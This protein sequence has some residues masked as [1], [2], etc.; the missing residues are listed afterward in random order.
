MEN[1]PGVLV[2][3]NVCAATFPRVASVLGLIWC[4]AR[5]MYQ[6]GYQTKGPSGRSKGSHIAVAAAI[7][8]VYP[9]SV[10]S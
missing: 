4:V 10:R 1:L 8:M 5:V 7:A 2:T 6:I 9:P 3:F